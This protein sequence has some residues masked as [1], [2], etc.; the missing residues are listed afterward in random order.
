VSA[1]SSENSDYADLTNAA[2]GR[3]HVARGSQWCR[4][5]YAGRAAAKPT[6]NFY[7]GAISIR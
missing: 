4:K 1:P 2:V 6:W 5:R 3:V 7:G